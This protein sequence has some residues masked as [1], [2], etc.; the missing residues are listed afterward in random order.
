MGDVYIGMPFAQYPRASDAAQSKNLSSVYRKVV[1]VTDLSS[2]S[3]SI[4]EK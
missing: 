1:E 4:H 3:V 2:L